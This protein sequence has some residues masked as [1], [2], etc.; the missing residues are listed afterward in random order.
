V[1]TFGDFVR[2]KTVILKAGDR[3][4]AKPR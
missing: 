2:D 1:V 3:Y 4:V